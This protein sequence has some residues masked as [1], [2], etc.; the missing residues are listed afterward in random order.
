MLSETVVSYKCTLKFVGTLELIVVVGLFVLLTPLFAHGTGLGINVISNVLGNA[1]F[2]YMYT[3]VCPLLYGGL[4]F[5]K[6]KLVTCY[7]LFA[8]TYLF[9][10][11]RLNPIYQKVFTTCSIILP[12]L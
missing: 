9:V 6:K 4:S 2:L 5:L 11:C 3:Q 1:C 12:N 10:F 7:L 8:F